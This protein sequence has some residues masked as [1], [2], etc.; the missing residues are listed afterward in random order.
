MSYIPRRRSEDSYPGSVWRFIRRFFFLVGVMATI[1][2]VLTSLALSRLA[3]ESAAPLPEK[4]LLTYTLTGPLQE[5]ES[6]PS[7]ARPFL[8]LSPTPH[9]LMQSI[10]TAAADARVK[11]LVIKIEGADLNI[12]QIQELRDAVADFR[13]TGKFA[14]IYSDNYGA[15]AGGMADYYLAS[16]FDQIWLQPVGVMAA[17]GISAEIPFI[18]DTLDK[19]GVN[20]EF[21]HKGIYK[22]MPESLTLTGMSDANREMM[23]SLIGDLYAQII[24]DIATARNIDP[25][26]LKQQLNNSPLSDHQALQAHLVDQLGYE[27]DMIATASERAGSG[28]NGPVDLLHYVDRAEHEKKDITAALKKKK[29]Q[30]KIALLIGAGEILPY[31]GK[32]EDISI[33]QAGI[34][35]I[36][37]NALADIFKKAADDEDVAAIV[38]RVDSPGGSPAASETIRHALLKAKEKG[39]PVIVSMGG[40]AASGGYWM[41]AAADKIVAQPGT[42][43]GSIGVFG[44]KFVLSGLWDKLGVRWD[45][46]SAGTASRM[47]SANKP[48]SEE[49]RQRLDA[50]ME[51]TYKTFLD[52]VAEG[53]HMSP[54]A[55]KAVAEGRVWTGRQAK[56]NGLVDALGGLDTAIALAKE[57]AKLP[58]DADIP[59]ERFPQPKSPFEILIDLAID[60]ALFNP[61]INIDTAHILSALKEFPLQENP[62]KGIR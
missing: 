55:V 58:A 14:W 18:K 37:A 12:A 20:A 57:A 62:L 29:G 32:T 53:R 43:T 25:A 36:K 17:G 49:E 51:N 15:M 10:Q 6:R 22:S 28:D 60:G 48:F 31:G 27:D 54:E 11:G 19:I 40:T 33:P 39:K 41:A 8:Q 13:K 59:V 42:L 52:I 16:A 56:E 24:Q 46:V 35:Y 4:I 23:T 5:T 7:I 1:S 44:G 30:P 47:W 3:G 61:S 21:I 38:F 26:L 2:F 45:S 34:G 50:L 9:K